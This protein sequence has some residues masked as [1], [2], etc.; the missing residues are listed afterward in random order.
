MQNQIIAD[1]HD[2]I[3]GV[4]VISSIPALIKVAKRIQLYASNLQRQQV[5]RDERK[6]LVHEVLNEAAWRCTKRVSRAAVSAPKTETVGRL[7]SL[8]G[9]IA[10]R[11]PEEDIA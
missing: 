9:E 6:E 11:I 10:R 8:I 5:A 3:I 7:I 4:G 2:A 1:Q